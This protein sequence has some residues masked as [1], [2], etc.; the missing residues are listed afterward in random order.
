MDFVVGWKHKLSWLLTD[1][2]GIQLEDIVCILLNYDFISNWRMLAIGGWYKRPPNS[3]LPIAVEVQEQNPF[4]CEVLSR[5]ILSSFFTSIVEEK[6]CFHFL[7]WL[8]IHTICC[9]SIIE[10]STSFWRSLAKRPASLLQ[11]FIIHSV[12]YYLK[13][14]ILFNSSVKIN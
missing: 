3:L 6:L 5:E 14:V 2:Q 9:R 1:S 8:I 7:F 4:K 11:S 13:A 10:V 12:K